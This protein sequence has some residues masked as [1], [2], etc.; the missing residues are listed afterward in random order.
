MIRSRLP[1]QRDVLIVGGGPAGSVTAALLA[2]AGWSVGVLERAVL[3]RPKPCGE[4]LN[5]GAVSV[6]RR[7]GMLERVLA[8]SP[9]TL[10]GWEIRSGSIRAV[11]NFPADVGQALALPRDVLD[12]ALVS[13]ARESGA[14]VEE[15][16]TVRRVAETPW[17]GV[18]TLVTRGP[19]GTPGMRSGRLIVG[20]DGLRSAVARSIGAPR[21]LPRLRKVSLTVRV[22]GRRAT[23][24]RGV[25]VIEQGTTVGLAPVNRAATSWNLTVVVIGTLARAAT[26]DPITFVL[27]SARSAGLSWLEGPVVAEG[28]WAS[29]PFDWPMRRVTADGLL[30]V[31]DAAGYYDPLTGQG[32]FRALRSAEIAA[33]TIDD[34]LRGGRVTNSDLKGYALRH[35]TAFAVGGAV[36]RA[37]EQVVSRRPLRDRMVG[38]LAERPSALRAL[39]GVTGDGAPASSLLRP[40]VLSAFLLPT[41]KE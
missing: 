41:R 9:A 33:E 8:L 35:R 40:G 3:P 4:C 1:A 24:D 38:R 39:L 18:R 37:V 26:L 2:Q 23:S 17:D 22:R 32:I 36:Q 12:A 6:L 30:L 25:V 31:G 29:G 7:I 15:G 5:P 16:V 21:R 28:P 27:D 13:A 10:E 20:A 34:A 11:A 14:T 19:D